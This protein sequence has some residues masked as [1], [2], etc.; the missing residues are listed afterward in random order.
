MRTPLN[1]VFM[2]IQLATQE[3][4]SLEGC[5][6]VLDIINSVYTSCSVSIEILN[7]ML[8]FDRLE[9]QGDVDMHFQTADMSQLVDT[10]AKTFIIQVK[11]SAYACYNN[12]Y[13]RQYKAI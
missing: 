8:L 1:T 13:Y 9:H 2:G 5:E 4:S 6:E 11:E 12:S 7:D 10:I 3:I